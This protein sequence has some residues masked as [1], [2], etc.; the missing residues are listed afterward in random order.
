MKTTVT[1]EIDTDQLCSATD[2][3]VAQLWHI[4]QANPADIDNRDAGE[5]AELVGRE[6]VRRWL[7]SQ[8]PELW[9][10]QGRH[11]AYGLLTKHA[12][13]PGPD[14]DTYVPFNTASQT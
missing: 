2:S 9:A 7:M 10:H 8:E 1:F 14:H 5:L 11:Y 12:S 6:I 13:W 3:Y 4:S